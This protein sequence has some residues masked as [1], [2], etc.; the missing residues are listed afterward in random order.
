[1]LGALRGRQMKLADSHKR[2]VPL[3]LKIAPTWTMRRSRRSPAS[4]GATR[5]TR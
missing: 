2:Y 4:S 3:A 1:M 5:S